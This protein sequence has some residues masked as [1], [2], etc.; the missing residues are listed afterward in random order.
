MTR[1]LIYSGQKGQH[2]LSLEDMT[3]NLMSMYR[4][5]S[6]NGLADERTRFTAF[7]SSYCCHCNFY[8]VTNVTTKIPR[9]RTFFIVKY[10]MKNGYNSDIIHRYFYRYL[11]QYFYWYFWDLKSRGK[12]LY[13]SASPDNIYVQRFKLCTISA[14]VNFLN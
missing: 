10:F 13:S 6:L 14:R 7:Y 3:F 4:I 9:Y 8:F 12:Y 1:H 2:T 5:A 11:Y